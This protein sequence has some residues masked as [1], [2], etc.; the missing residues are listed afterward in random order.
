VARCVYKFVISEG[1]PGKSYLSGRLM[2]LVRASGNLNT[3]EWKLARTSIRRR[4]QLNL[5]KQS[6]PDMLY[7][8]RCIFRHSKKCFLLT[9]LRI[10][11]RQCKIPGNR[12]VGRKW[13]GKVFFCKKNRKIGGVFCKKK[14][15]WVFF[16]KS[17]KCRCVFF[18]KKWTFFQRRVHHVQYQ[19][20]FLFYILLIWGAYAPNAPPCIRAWGNVKLSEIHRGIV[21]DV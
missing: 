21:I 3:V 14:W 10:V 1:T 6:C 9:P 11:L 13:N 17:G 4:M 12:P 16:V 18:C 19:Y 20:F 15:K 2:L 8:S 7:C 5:F